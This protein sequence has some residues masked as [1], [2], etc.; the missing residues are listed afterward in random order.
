MQPVDH[1]AA[2]RVR[3]RVALRTHARLL[4]AIVH[5]HRWAELPALDAD[6]SALARHCAGD[7]ARDPELD[8]TLRDLA[9][10]YAV[11]IRGLADARAVTGHALAGLSEFEER[12]MAYAATNGSDR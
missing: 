4:R 10:A 12:G 11:A 3:L 2:V 9:R 8:T 5:E 7:G 1:A 6:V